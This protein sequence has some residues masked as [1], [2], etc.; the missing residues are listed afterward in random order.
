MLSSAAAEL[1]TSLFFGLEVLSLSIFL[2]GIMSLF[3][4]QG[5]GEVPLCS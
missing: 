2:Q 5:L 3:I 1:N 4:T